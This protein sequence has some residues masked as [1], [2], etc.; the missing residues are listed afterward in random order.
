MCSDVYKLFKKKLIV[1]QKTPIIISD[2]PAGISPLIQKKTQGK[3]CRS[4]LVANGATLM[5]YAIG[6]NDPEKL[7]Q[8]LTKQRKKQADR[9]LRDDSALL[10]AYRMGMP[11]IGSIFLGIDRII[12]AL[13][14]VENINDLAMKM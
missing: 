6:E 5:E 8:E 9:Y 4:Y 10:H 1:N 7:E 13:V 2:L 12:P 14:G 3:L 11:L